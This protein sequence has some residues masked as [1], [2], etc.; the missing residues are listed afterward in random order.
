MCPN[1]LLMTATPH[2]GKEAEFQ[3]FLSLL[4]EAGREEYVAD[5]TSAGLM[6]RLVKEQ[7]VHLDGSRLFPERRA[8]TVAYRLSGLEHDLYEDVS[9]YVREEMNKVSGDDARA[10]RRLRAARP[11]A[12]PGLVAG[13]DP[14]LVGH[15]VAT[16][17]TGEAIRVRDADDRLAAPRR[18]ASGSELPDVDELSP[19]DAETYEDDTA[20]V[21]TAARTLEELET[22][23]AI[24]ERLVT[25]PRW[26]G[27]PGWTPSGRP[28]PSC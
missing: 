16:V 2:N 17:C 7:L 6:R 27:P 24:L 22:E 9:E 28:S 8:S 5:A 1:L 10:D 18:R 4:R 3:L 23:I 13:G 26:C 12:A 19:A 20:S 15:A 25:R 14:P 11:P 21:A